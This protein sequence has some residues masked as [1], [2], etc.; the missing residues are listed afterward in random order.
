[1]TGG[2]KSKLKQTKDLFRKTFDRFY[3]NIKK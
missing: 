2:L 1:M 3:D